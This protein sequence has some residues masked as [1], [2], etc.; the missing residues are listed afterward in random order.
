MVP[1]PTIALAGHQHRRLARGDAGEVLAELDL[2]GGVASAPRAADG[3]R[4]G[5]RAVA[6]LDRVDARA[7]AVQDGV[8]DADAALLQ[9]ARGCRP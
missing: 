6:Q 8:A 1:W 9:L 4:E 2:Q 5:A 7:V 3:G